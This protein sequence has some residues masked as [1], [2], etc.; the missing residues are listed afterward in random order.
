MYGTQPFK[1]L[2]NTKR[3]KVAACVYCQFLQIHQCSIVERT[4]YIIRKDFPPNLLDRLSQDLV[5]FQISQRVTKLANAARSQIRKPIFHRLSDGEA[6]QIIS[7][8]R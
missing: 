2:S 1:E 4:E 5:H 8:Q 6:Q 3:Y 7:C